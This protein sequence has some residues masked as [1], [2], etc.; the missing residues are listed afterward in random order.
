MSARIAVRHTLVA[1]FA[2]CPPAADVKPTDLSDNPSLP[3]AFP[4]SL[5]AR[6]R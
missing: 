6:E 5:G 1:A 3:P 4:A 2:T